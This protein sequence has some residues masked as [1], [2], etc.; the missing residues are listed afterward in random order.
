VKPNVDAKRPRMLKHH[1]GS[2][3][4]EEVDNQMTS[5]TYLGSERCV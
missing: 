4:F 5:A 2:T 3:C 1:S